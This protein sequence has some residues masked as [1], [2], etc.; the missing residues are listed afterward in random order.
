MSSQ[1]S[2]KNFFSGKIL[3][4]PRYQRSYAWEKQN[5]SELFE[6]I[7]EAI[8][9]QSQHYLGTV[10]LARTN[11][12]EVYT[13][14][15]GQQRLTTLLIFI[16]CIVRNLPHDQ[17]RN[18][19][20]RL[21]IEDGGRFKLTPLEHDRL[22][23]FQLLSL[24]VVPVN[25]LKPQNKS[26]KFLLEAFEEIGN[27]ADDHIP[28]PK[29]FLKSI[30]A[31][32]ILEFIEKDESD[33]IRIFQTV[34]DRG[35]ELSRMD[36]MKSLLFY[37]SDKYLNRQYDDQI[38]S[39][40]ADIFA[41]YDEIK[42][43][44]ERQFIN[45]INSKQFTEDDLLRHH[46]ICFSEESYDPTAQEV[47]DNVKR[48][49]YELRQ[50]QNSRAELDAYLSGYLRSLVSY[51]KAFRNV[52][53]RVEQSSEYYKLFSIQ[54]LAVALYPVVAQLENSQLL[55][56]VLP[57]RGISVLKMLGII[58]LR[59]FKVRQYAGRKH[60]SNL[61]F[62]LNNEPWS[63]PEIE[64][65]LVWFNTFEISDARFIEYMS[66]YDYYK[67]TGLLRS[68]FIDYCERLRNK[69]YTLSE[70][71]AL[72]SKNPTIEHILS[73]TPK[74]S[75]K[76]FSFKSEQDFDEYVNLLGNLTLL[77][78][79]LNSSAQ[80]ASLGEKADV[81]KKSGLKMTSQLGTALTANP[82]FKKK[83]LMARGKDLAANFATWWPA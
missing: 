55:D 78:K 65:H 22:F 69:Q 29:V 81:Y 10:V 60:A 77:E 80:N 59:L 4:I 38:N 31:L 54:G 21:Y 73:Q 42:L 50:D 36:K 76:S 58:D 25:Q 75:P 66:S 71:Q 18:F 30:E 14:V 56:Q 16:A 83:E 51:V 62:R 17:D 13:V 53:R 68:L 52:V 63:L 79:R 67:Q 28:D 20:H 47:H 11:D 46:H 49:L 27:L 35:K 64:Q 61:A 33:A 12:P 15:D 41:W 2:L 1:Q 24:G 7:K 82:G 45:T 74:F 48:H 70:L 19:Y 3:E 37:F 44:G 39:G 43:I 23:Y 40:F 34:N 32:S 9:T 57:G 5:V 6:D 26:Q 8:D 72:M